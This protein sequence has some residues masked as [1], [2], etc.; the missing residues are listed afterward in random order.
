MAKDPFDRIQ[1]ADDYGL[2]DWLYPA[3]AKLC[4]RDASLTFEE[5]RRIGFERFAV[6][7]K[8]REDDFK[9]TIRTRNGSFGTPVFA[10]TT[11]T[12]GTTVYSNPH[13]VQTPE[14]RTN[15]TSECYRLPFQ[16][17]TRE[18]SFLKKIAREKALQ[19][20]GTQ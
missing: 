1:I 20:E 17:S 11:T 8:I 7:V 3:Y 16:L 19:A 4:A 6:L 12:F 13:V 2:T 9:D 14:P 5:G 18:K 10:A 15:C